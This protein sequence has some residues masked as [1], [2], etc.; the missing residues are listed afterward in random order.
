MGPSELG[1]P[2]WQAMMLQ[3]P[4]YTYLRWQ[5]ALLPEGDDLRNSALQLCPQLLSP[6]EPDLQRLVLYAWPR[7]D[8]PREV[9]FFDHRFLNEDNAAASRM[10]LARIVDLLK[11]APEV[12]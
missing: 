12:S 9:I 10:F 3:V 4:P 1:I 2:L 11:V 5:F 8:G 7:E 6:E